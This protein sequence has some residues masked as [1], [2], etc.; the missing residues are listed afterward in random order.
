M[1]MFLLKFSMEIFFC[2]G[3]ICDK[4]LQGNFHD[5]TTGV[6]FFMT[7]VLISDIIDSSPDILHVDFKQMLIRL[8]SF[9]V[10]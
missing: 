3:G 6:I 2:T 7:L 8:S 9:R 10:P 1:V 4:L 5:T